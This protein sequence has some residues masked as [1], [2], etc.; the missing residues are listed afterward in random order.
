[1]AEN[2]KGISL[3]PHVEAVHD[4]CHILRMAGYV[5]LSDSVGAKAHA[6]D[7][8]M[9]PGCTN[10]DLVHIVARLTSEKREVLSHCCEI[11][12]LEPKI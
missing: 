10:E 4:A 5:T 1:M 8:F 9:L 7:C 6:N 11:G 2:V 3:K 12:Q